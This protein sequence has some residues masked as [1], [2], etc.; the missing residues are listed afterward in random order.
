ML[1][2]DDRRRPVR[3]MQARDLAAS[4]DTQERRGVE[5][6]AVEPSATLAAALES[7]VG[8]HVG[9]VAV[10]DGSGALLGCLDLGTIMTAV[11]SMRTVAATN[12]GATADEMA[13][14]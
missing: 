5:V 14:R 7:L 9:V 10:V 3:W 2:L 4:G 6:H 13:S 11:E 8:S 12:R 1:L